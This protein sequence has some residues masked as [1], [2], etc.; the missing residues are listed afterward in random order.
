[1]QPFL[2]QTVMA[3]VGASDAVKAYSKKNLPALGTW[4]TLKNPDLQA[5]KKASSKAR[6]AAFVTGLDAAL[7][8]ASLVLP[9]ELVLMH[10]FK[11]S[12]VRRIA[13]ISVGSLRPLEAS[14]SRKQLS[15]KL[16]E[17]LR[18]QKQA[19]G[20]TAP[21]P[22]AVAPATAAAAA[23]SERYDRAAQNQ[24]RERSRTPPR[25]CPSAV[26]KALSRRETEDKE[27]AKKP[28][29]TLVVEESP[30]KVSTPELQEAAGTTEEEAAALALDRLFDGRP[31]KEEPT[32]Q[33]EEERQVAVEPAEKAEEDVPKEAGMAVEEAEAEQEAMS[34]DGPAER[35]VGARLDSFM[36]AF[37]K[38][39][40][41]PGEYMPCMPIAE[42]RAGLAGS[43]KAAEVDVGLRQ[44]D[45]ANKVL[46]EDMMVFAL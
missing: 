15:Q 31:G 7:G 6:L 8:Q 36:A 22:A 32:Q 43:F 37:S 19:S 26:E 34:V 21:T 38:L 29:T 18:K 5:S 28:L 2:G 1:M 23:S 25:R 46:L 12:P 13:G 9:N 24:S 35:L 33:G 16:L 3:P 4:V 45:E 10:G 20:S 44:L 11:G 40:Y 42:V 30:K 41:K 14:A 39:L 17:A 27:P